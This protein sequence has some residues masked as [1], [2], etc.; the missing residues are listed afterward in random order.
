MCG[1]PISVVRSGD[2]GKAGRSTGQ[3]HRLTVVPWRAELGVWLPNAVA[4]A[5]SAPFTHS[6]SH[7]TNRDTPAALS[8]TD[9]FRLLTRPLTGV[10][11][12]PAHA[13]LYER[14][15]LTG[16]HLEAGEF[17]W[18]GGCDDTG[19]HAGGGIQRSRVSLI[20]TGKVGNNSR[21]VLPEA[22]FHLPPSLSLSSSS[23]LPLWLVAAGFSCFLYFGPIRSTTRLMLRRSKTMGRIKS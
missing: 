8:P 12:V 20:F 22:S 7:K 6:C 21:L 11:S 23:L 10:R 16:T 13:C 19:F 18:D 3:N 9:C 17:A 14:A 1:W 2:G 5:T 4:P 15:R